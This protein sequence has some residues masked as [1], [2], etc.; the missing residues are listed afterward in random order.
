MNENA[1]VAVPAAVPAAS[2][3]EAEVSR[4]WQWIVANPK[5]A[6]RYVLLSLAFVGYD[7]TVPA[8]RAADAVNRLGEATQKVDEAYKRIDELERLLRDVADKQKMQIA[9]AEKR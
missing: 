4:W 3:V 1:P 8:N 6:I 5:Q 7:L 2:N 9:L